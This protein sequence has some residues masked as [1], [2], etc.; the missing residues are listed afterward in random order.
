MDAFADSDGGFPMEQPQEV[1]EALNQTPEDTTKESLPSTEHLPSAEQVIESSTEAKAQ[2]GPM[3]E[4]KEESKPTS[5]AKTPTEPLPK[6]EPRKSPV[7]QHQATQNDAVEE[8]NDDIAKMLL[9]NRIT[10]HES[11]KLQAILRENA[12]LKEKVAK[13]KTLLARSA[14]ASKE[15]KQEN[16]EYKKLL[17]V[18]KK[19][20]ERLNERVEALASRPTHMDLLADFETNFDR[21]LMNLHTDEAPSAEYVRQTVGQ[22]TEQSN[23]EENVSN[24]LM[25]EL[26]Q[27]KSRVEHL[28]NMNASLKKRSIQ[29]EKQNEQLMQE[30]QSGK[31]I[32]GEFIFA[33]CFLSHN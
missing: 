3:G 12:I 26:N 15:T 5:A 33:V 18:A 32:L 14:K 27:T 20:V 1:E 16:I 9:E 17:D 31:A 8:A 2:N 22:A 30:K 29:L 25:A 28:E 11:S 6:V 13:L 10:M 23:E 4:K 19:E 21:A 24:M 7:R